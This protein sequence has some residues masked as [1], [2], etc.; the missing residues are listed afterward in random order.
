MQ[1][2]TQNARCNDKKKMKLALRYLTGLDRTGLIFDWKYAQC[3]YIKEVRFY[4]MLPCVLDVG[5]LKASALIF[6]CKAVQQFLN[7]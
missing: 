2:E 3:F 4:E 5:S 1:G 7:A 6:K